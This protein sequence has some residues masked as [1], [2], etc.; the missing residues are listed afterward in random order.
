MKIIPAIDIK[1]GKCVRLIQGDYGRET[2]YGDNPVEMA[3]KWV[4]EGAQVLHLVDLDGAKAG[5]LINLKVIEDI[6]RSVPIPLQV[7]GG[8]RS[9]SS[10]NKLIEVGVSKIILGTMALCD[11]KLS[12]TA[13]DL[14]G[15]KII[16]SLD[17]KN[18]LLMKNGWIEKSEVMIFPM[19]KILERKGVKSIIFTDIK[20]DGMLSEPNYEVIQSLRDYTSMEI[21]VAGGISD[22]EQFIALKK[23][24]INGIIVG[25]ALYDRKLYLNK[26]LEYVN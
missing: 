13:L 18:G 23:M 8:I 19:I 3:K 17:V 16:I 14:F 10:M 7:G 12:D 4:A 26:I 1:N 25:K 6:A 11:T 2:I 9:I 5:N 15:D 22:Y 21:I 20:I 24:K